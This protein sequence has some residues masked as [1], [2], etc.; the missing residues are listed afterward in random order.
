MEFIWTYLQWMFW[1][2]LALAGLRGFGYIWN[3]YV[4]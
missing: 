3:K 2:C 1:V 4:G